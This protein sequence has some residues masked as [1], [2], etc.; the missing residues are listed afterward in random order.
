MSNREQIVDEL[1]AQA[2]ELSPAERE[3]FLAERQTQ[4]DTDA[5]NSVIEDVR[6]LLTNY[7]RAESKAFLNTPFVSSNGSQTL[8]DGQEFE[9][10]RI[11]RLIAEGGMGEVY[12]AQD[13]E[14]KRRVAIK[15]IKGHATKDIL[16]RFATERQILANLQHPNIA[17]LHE[18]GATADGLPFFVMEYVEGKPIDEYVRDEDRSLNGCLKLFRT[19][20]SAV[21]YAHQNLIIHRDLKPANV[22]VNTGGEVKLLDFG[23][24]KLLHEDDG[25]KPEATATLFRAMTPQYA[26][27]EQVKG[28]PITTSSDVYSLGV[29][30]YEL[31]TGWR[32]YKLKLNIASEITKAICEQEPTKPSAACGSQESGAGSQSEAP[33]VAGGQSSIV[34]PKLLRGDLDNIVLKALR[35]EPERRYASV[36]QFSEDIRRHL[37]GLPVAARKDTFQYRA[38]KFIQRNKMATAAAVIVFLTLVFGIVA[39]S[40]GLTRARRERARAEA[41]EDANRHLLYAAQMSLAYQAWETANV[42]RALDLLE[43]QRPK[44]GEEDLRGFEWYLLSRLASERSQVLFTSGVKNWAVAFSGKGDRIAV[45]SGDGNARIWDA[46]TNQLLNSFDGRCGSLGAIAFSPDGN[47]LVSGCDSGEVVIWDVQ[48][49]EMA[50]RFGAHEGWIDYVDFSFDGRLLATAGEDRTVKIWD[51]EHRTELR[52]LKGHT[53]YIISIDFSPDGRTLATASADHTARLWD[54]SSGKEIATLK[55]HAWYV[56]GVAFSPNGQTLATTGSDGEIKL[57]DASR[58]TEVATIH[59]DGTSQDTVRFSPDGKTIAV[60]RGDGT[61]KLYDVVTRTLRDVLRGHADLAEGLAFSP[62]GSRLVSASNAVRV[63]DLTKQPGALVL[64]GHKD[65][66]WQIAFS[67]DGRT[68]ASASKDGSARLW[69]VADGRELAMLSHGQ[70]VNWVAFSPDGVRLATADDDKFVRLWNAATG[71]MVATL[72]GHTAVAEC[73]TFS[74]DGKLLASGG[75]TGEI[76]LWDPATGQELITLYSPDHNPIWSLAFSPDGKYL[77]AAEGGLEALG[78][79][80]GHLLTVWD[81]SS[82]QLLKT[83]VGH[84]SDVRAIA[85]SPDGKL[86]ASGSFDDTIKLWDVTTWTEVASLRTHKVQ[87]IAFSPDGK[88][89]ASGGRDKTIKIWDVATRQELC[90][91]TTPVE[92]NAVAFSPDNKVLAAASSDNKVRLW[93]AATKDETGQ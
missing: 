25:N 51:F 46:A 56:N 58:H 71:E 44:P 1:F 30:L 48:K 78:V 66:T 69:N 4:S 28:E 83:L 29:L 41:G 33:A 31:L 8:R 70:W 76:K 91:L 42:G 3:R 60:S 57:W 26:S 36:E 93:F 5:D 75:K 21:S 43:A 55:G 64:E 79:E 85:F 14:L 92:V 65:I 87:G 15:L 9:G 34:N 52:T 50:K 27:P 88:R 90:S 18:A 49:G 35:K 24:A 17:Q 20:C 62:D 22:I 12:L 86:L 72:S 6:I 19:V 45:A 16:R 80:T 23:I 67:P 7:R 63:W 47:Y 38:S 2:L 10:Y 73:A 13:E 61:L 81:V 32:P 59:G 53:G 68:I 11:V 82:R 84:S 54:V 40:I 39:T 89:L 77:V 74:P 37:E